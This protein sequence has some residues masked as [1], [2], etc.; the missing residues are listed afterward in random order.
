MLE[1]LSTTQKALLGLAAAGAVGFGGWFVYRTFFDKK[2]GTEDKKTK[3]LDLKSPAAALTNDLVTYL[4][5]CNPQQGDT[6]TA[7]IQLNNALSGLSNGNLRGLQD[8]FNNQKSDLSQAIVAVRNC[9]GQ[10]DSVIVNTIMKYVSNLKVKL[11]L[12]S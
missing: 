11:G 9:S 5:M 10:S 1:S 4:T 7:I 12:G 6:K 2:D 8:A 3:N